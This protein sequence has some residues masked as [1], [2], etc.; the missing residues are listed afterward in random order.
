[1][2]E[3][4]KEFEPESDLLALVLQVSG[5]VNFTSWSGIHGGQTNTLNG[6]NPRMSLPADPNNTG[7]T[8]TDLF[9]GINYIHKTGVRLATEIGKTIH[10]DVQGVQLGNDWSLNL[11]VQYAF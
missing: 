1:M 11:G 3:A 2:R 5:R 8:R 7:G 10:Q 4:I 6:M 9:L